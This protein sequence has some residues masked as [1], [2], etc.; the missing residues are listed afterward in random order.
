MLEAII[1]FLNARLRVLFPD[2][3][4][5]GLCELVK[6][7][8]KDFVAPAEYCADGTYKHIDF[9]AHKGLVYYR[10][11]GDVSVSKVDE[12]TTPTCDI[13][14]SHTF[15][16]KLVMYAPKDYYDTD[17][18]HID[19][20]LANNVKKAIQTSNDKTLNQTLKSSLAS[21]LV[22]DYTTDR[23]TVIGTEYQGAGAEV[24]IPF[25]K[26]LISLDI[27]V[28]IE[29]KL[30]C[31]DYYG[32]DD[33]VT[34][35]VFCP[36]VVNSNGEVLVN[37]SGGSGEVTI[38]DSKIYDTD[39]NELYSVPATEDQ[40]IQ[41]GTIKNSAGTAIGTVLAEGE[42][43]LADKLLL[44]SDSV[45]SSPIVQGVDKTIQD[46]I[47]TR[48]DG[49]NMAA[50]PYRTT[51]V[52]TQLQRSYAYPIPTG[53]TTIFRTGDD[54]WVQQNIFNALARGWV[55]PLVSF[56]VLSEN[57]V[58][59]NTDRFTDTNGLQ[60]YGESYMIDNFTGLGWYL[61]SPGQT[62]WNNQIDAALALSLVIAGSTY[63]DWFI[64]N[65][66]QYWSI[67]NKGLTHALNYAPF[68]IAGATSFRSST[69]VSTN[70]TNAYGLLTNPANTNMPAKSGSDPIFYCRKHF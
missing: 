70:S 35:V 13:Y 9:D 27:E 41:D 62:S 52:S 36:I 43:T 47:I 60:V 42:T 57:N 46:V 20:K 65:V 11:N 28:K 14:E 18:A 59:G 22:T 50:L 67:L 7:D 10:K 49:V 58:F 24:S 44:S 6:D 2:F 32:C 16:L 23:N 61:I 15:P 12:S 54:A 45:Y 1:L 55:A 34:E 3:E 26:A 30:S 66:N 51:M 17:N 29:G 4:L 19:D 33:E 40:I 53:Q 64:P 69:T 21:I 48:Y 56:F 5:K 37:G 38:Q 39:G 25:D 63:D 31:F 8:E 68:N